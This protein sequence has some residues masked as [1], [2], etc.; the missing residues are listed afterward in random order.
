M[1]ECGLPSIQGSVARACGVAPGLGQSVQVCPVC[2][3][4]DSEAKAG[5]N[6]N[7]R[8][9]NKGYLSVEFDE[10]LRILDWTGWQVRSDK[11]AA[12]PGSTAC[13]TSATGSP[14]VAMVADHY[15]QMMDV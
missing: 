9:S 15:T 12:N 8:A 1:L 13:R 6:R 5:R 4:G 11:R 14:M 7:R 10:Y 3:D 2:V